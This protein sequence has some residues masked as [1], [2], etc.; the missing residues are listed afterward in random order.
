MIPLIINTPEAMLKIRVVTAKDSS[1]ETLER[2]Q[3]MGVLH[4]EEPRELDLT[5]RTAIDE[6]RNLT[7]KEIS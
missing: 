3:E 2:L 5:D 7:K 6:K 4:I 1:T